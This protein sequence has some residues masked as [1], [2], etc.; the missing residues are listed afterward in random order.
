MQLPSSIGRKE[1]E[2]VIWRKRAWISFWTSSSGFS[3]LGAGGVSAGAEFSLSV[4][5]AVAVLAEG[6][7]KMLTCKGGC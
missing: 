3:A 6:E 1:T 2:A 7:L 4:E 5:V